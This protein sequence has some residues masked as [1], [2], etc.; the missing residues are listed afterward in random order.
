MKMLND[1][2]IETDWLCTMLTF[3]HHNMETNDPCTGRPFWNKTTLTHMRVCTLN[4]SEQLENYK[5]AKNDEQVPLPVV[6]ME[7]DAFK[8][9]NCAPMHMLHLRCTKTTFGMQKIG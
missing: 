9:M 7:V 5:A 1:M 8:K 6:W 2:A 3:S 4:K